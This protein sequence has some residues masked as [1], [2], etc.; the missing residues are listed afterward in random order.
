MGAWALI[1]AGVWC[2]SYGGVR[3]LVS[4]GTPYMVCVCVVT[5]ILVGVVTSHI[6][7]SFVCATCIVFQFIFDV[8]IHVLCW[9]VFEVGVCVCV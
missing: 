8:C 3:R 2:L 7:T 9:F 1:L 5:P 4:V 6:V